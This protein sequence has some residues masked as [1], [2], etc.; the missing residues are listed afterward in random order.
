MSELINIVATVMRASSHRFVG[1]LGRDPEVKFLDSGK[2]VANGRIAINVPGSKQG[3]G[4]EPDWFTV[5]V[6]EEEAQA[7]ADRCRKGDLVE[8]IGRV[9]TNRWTDRTTGEP[10]L[11][12]V[13]TADKWSLVRSSGQ[14]GAPAPAPAPGQHAHLAAAGWQPNPQ[15]G[16]V[17]APGTWNTAPLAAP[18]ADGIPF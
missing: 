5:E 4:K 17:A 18:D 8:V 13:V 12:L 10:K 3:D 7:F 2:A 6:W 16:T 1:R 11:D 9:R 15:Q 14:P